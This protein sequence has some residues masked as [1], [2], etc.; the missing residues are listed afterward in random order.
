M[1]GEPLFKEI[2]NHFGNTKIP[3]ILSGVRNLSLL[4][5]HTAEMSNCRG[6]SAVIRLANNV[7]AQIEP[8]RYVQGIEHEAEASAGKNFRIAVARR[9]GG[10]S[11]EVLRSRNQMASPPFDSDCRS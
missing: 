3:L 1:R 8:L 9:E 2:K 11:G 7:T 5:E 10:I 6:A 4:F